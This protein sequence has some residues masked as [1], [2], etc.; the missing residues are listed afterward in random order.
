MSNDPLFITVANTFISNNKRCHFIV[1]A[2]TILKRKANGGEKF[3]RTVKI[4]QRLVY[5]K[6][7]L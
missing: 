1:A 2:E 3:S 4:L 6:F 7:F 5:P